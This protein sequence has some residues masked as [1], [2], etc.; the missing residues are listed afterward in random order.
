M[1][2]ISVAR[3]VLSIALEHTRAGGGGEIRWV[4]GRVAEVDPLSLQALMLRF[5]E[6]ARGTP[7]E[8]ARLEFDLVQARVRCRSCEAVFFSDCDGRRCLRCASEELEGADPTGL[9]VTALEV[10]AR[11]HLECRSDA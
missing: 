7:A 11:G 8:G 3:R 2:E 10:D 4:R 5:A 6:L 1:N 9:W